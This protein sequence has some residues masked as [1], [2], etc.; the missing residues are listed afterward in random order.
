[1]ERVTKSKKLRVMRKLLR[2]CFRNVAPAL[3]PLE[4]WWEIVLG[5]DVR[6][7]TLLAQTS[8]AFWQLVEEIR[9]RNLWIALE[10][11][12]IDQIPLARK[13]LTMCANHGIPEAMFHIG[14]AKFHKGFGFKNSIYLHNDWIKKAAD[15]GYPL[16]MAFLICQ[17]GMIRQ[18]DAEKLIERVFLS[19][20]PCAIGYYY[21]K[22]MPTLISK[23]CV[24]NLKIV[25]EKGN[26]FAQYIL[27]GVYANGT[28][29]ILRDDEEAMYWYG[30][31]AHQGHFNSLQILSRFYH[32]KY[33]NQ[34]QFW[35]KKLKIHEKKYY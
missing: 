28:R 7:M 25:A 14:Y 11:R 2:K 34:C 22:R 3:V 5:T 13:C 27:A 26:E 29:D 9:R 6:D 33:N 32:N 17:P 30:K 15:V 35:R 19:K 10:Y 18:S 24:D 20:D 8:K 4:V 21:F 12:R 1:M 16:A 23:E 31:A